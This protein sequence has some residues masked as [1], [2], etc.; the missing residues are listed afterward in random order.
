MKHKLSP[1]DR[2]D[3]VVANWYLEDFMMLGAWS[4]VDKVPDPKHL[5][6]YHGGG[7]LDSGRHGAI[8]PR[9]NM[10]NN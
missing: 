8:P 5:R 4:M 3:K 2:M 1:E 6:K 10:E 9:Y 7:R